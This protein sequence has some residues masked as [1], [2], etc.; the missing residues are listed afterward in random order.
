MFCYSNGLDYVRGFR[1]AVTQ[2]KNGR[3]V[4]LI[5]CTNLLNL[6]HVHEKD[7]GWETAYPSEDEIMGF[8]DIRQFGDKG[9]HLIITYGNG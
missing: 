1:N 9:K 3:V 7:R 4:M 2:A 6:R 8:N 5:D